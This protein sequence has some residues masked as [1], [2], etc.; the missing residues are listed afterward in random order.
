M[1]KINMNVKI[2]KYTSQVLGV[3]K[4]KFGLSGKS[5]ALDK[6]ADMFGDEFVERDVSDDIVLDAIRSAEAHAKKYCNRKMSL[7]E[8]SKL[9]DV[10]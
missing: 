7:K 8:L 5:E 3:V 4:E 1:Q 2:S 6:L 10:V 9:C